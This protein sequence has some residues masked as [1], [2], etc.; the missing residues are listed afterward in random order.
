MTLRIATPGDAY[1]LA[2]IY[3]YYVEQ[4]AITFE[5]DAPDAAEFAERIAHK[6]EKY[7]YLVAEVDGEVVGYAYASELRERAAFGWDAELSVY[8]H[9]D[10]RGRGIGERLYSALIELLKLQRFVALYAC[11]T[12]PN[13]PSIKL[14]E[15][16]G[17]TYAGRFKATGY[18]RGKWHDVLWYEKRIGGDGKPLPVID[19]PALDRKTVEQILKNEVFS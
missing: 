1:A 8:L 17:F 3:A 15:K 19:F 7:P 13:E 11:I 6:L 14:H 2:E 9:P 12:S 5:Y 16:L 18:K 4:T 10:K